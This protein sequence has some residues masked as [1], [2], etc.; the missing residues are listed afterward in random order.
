MR[1]K[2]EELFLLIA[3]S[4]IYS[5]SSSIKVLEIWVIEFILINA[6]KIESLFNLGSS[7]TRR[8]CFVAGW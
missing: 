5:F 8:L 2:K 6:V 7:R 1:K 4:K 3:F